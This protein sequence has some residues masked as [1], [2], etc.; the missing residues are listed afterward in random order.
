MY[1]LGSYDVVLRMLARSSSAGPEPAA[2]QS[3]SRRLQHFWWGSILIRL[4]S[5]PVEAPEGLQRWFL[6]LVM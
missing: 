3:C 2:S 5:C 1:T 4:V 6:W